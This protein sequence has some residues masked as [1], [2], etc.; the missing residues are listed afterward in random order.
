MVREHARAVNTRGVPRIVRTH[1][2][3][4]RRRRS[5]FSIYTRGPR[6]VVGGAGAGGQ[7]LKIKTGDLWTLETAAPPTTATRAS[8]GN[9]CGATIPASGRRRD[10]TAVYDCNNII[11]VK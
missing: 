5:H 11:I 7:C 2:W 8:V 6:A 4:R 9:T 1:R 3:R 10:S